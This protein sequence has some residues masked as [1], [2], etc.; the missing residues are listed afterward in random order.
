MS[1]LLKE[2]HRLILHLEKVERETLVEGMRHHPRAAVRERCA[3]LLKVADG[4][5][6]HAVAKAGLLFARDPD[7]VYRWLDWYQQEGIAGL[8]S[9]QQGGNQRGR[10]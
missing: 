6:P 1:Q 10:L 2:H 4:V 7:S 5:S 9:H 8:L 3:A